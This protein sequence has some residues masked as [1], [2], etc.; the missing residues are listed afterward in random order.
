MNG[1]DLYGNVHF[2]SFFASVL[3]RLAYFNDTNFLAQYN[4]IIGPVIPNS[5]LKEI[6]AISAIPDILDDESVFHLQEN[7]NRYP[8]YQYEGKRYIAFN[9]MAKKINEI[10]GEV[11]EP[12]ISS[13][14]DRRLQSSYGN[15]AYISIATSNYGEIYVV[16]DKRM[17][18][19][20]W[21]VFR[22]TYSAKTAGAYSKPHSLVPIYVGSSEGKRE[23]YLY[24]IFKLLTDSIHT[25]IE[26]CRFLAMHHL[27]AKNPGS[28]KMFTTGHSLGGALCTLFAYV[29]MRVKKT[30]PY[31]TDAM[32]EV[33]TDQIGC[34]S[35]GAPRAINNDIS[36]LFCRYVKEGKIT[37]LRVTTRRDPVTAM[38]FKTTYFS[39]P[40]SDAIS[41]GE[42][43]REKVSE[44][45]WGLYES[46]YLSTRKPRVDYKGKLDCSN[47]KSG[48]Y[49]SNPLRH[50]IYLNILYRNAVDIQ[51]FL[52][53]A[54]T[55]AEV[56][57]TPDGDTECR[58]ILY[59]DLD[60][61]KKYKCAFFDVSKA[62][63]APVSIKEDNPEDNSNPKDIKE[64]VR[65][66][67]SAFDW[68]IDRAT[69]FTITDNL[70]MQ[71]SVLNPF[72]RDG[73]MPKVCIMLQDPV[74]GGRR[75]KRRRRT[76]KS[77]KKNKK[78]R[79]YF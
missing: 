75:S 23:S 77:I 32:Y 44:D 21:V 56:Q 48:T 66:T 43:L 26:A 64:D 15:T 36:E 76:Q 5:I 38:P 9:D 70:P 35:L 55:T 8:I 34:V 45:C 60:N 4:K 7:P 73:I 25:I 14:E 63:Q 50:T 10:N 47:K 3:S 2:I 33:M 16:A 41:V 22:G 71:G 18:N 11:E 31:S 30:A 40:C 52:A 13:E 72:T 65:M 67:P 49:I 68:L 74:K 57:R 19:C 61:A 59:R 28:V 27:K 79:K 53:S 51:A 12:Y 42:G 1:P 39:H 69:E 29:W 78:T 20:I 6:N 46:D 24:G 58:V 17:P 54:F 37:F 62:R